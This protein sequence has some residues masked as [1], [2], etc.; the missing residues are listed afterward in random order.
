MAAKSVAKVA[1][2]AFGIKV[3]DSTDPLFKTDPGRARQY[4]SYLLTANT[5]LPAEAGPRSFLTVV[6]NQRDVQLEVWEQAGAIASKELE[7]NTHIGDGSCRICRLASRDA[8]PGR[9]PA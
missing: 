5:P 6:D 8:V 3:T 1:P 7:H 4:I 2:R 9:L